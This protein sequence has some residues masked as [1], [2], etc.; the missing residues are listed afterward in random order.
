MYLGA[1]LETMSACASE[2]GLGTQVDPLS[3]QWETLLHSHIPGPLKE[4]D[5]DATTWE[6]L[7]PEFLFNF[8]RDFVVEWYE[9]YDPDCTEEDSMIR[10]KLLN[11]MCYGTMLLL[12]RDLVYVM[13]Y[14]FSGILLTN[15]FGSFLHIIV[16]FWNV[17]R[18][19][20]S[21]ASGPEELKQATGIDIPTDR[22][23]RPIYPLEA[24][25]YGKSIVCS[26]D[27]FYRANHS[28]MWWGFEE[29]KWAASK[30]GIKF[31]TG[32]QKSLT[33]FQKDISEVTFLRRKFRLLDGLW[34]APRPLEEIVEQSLWI[35]IKRQ[36]AQ[37]YLEIFEGV[38]REMIMHGRQNFDLTKKI[39]NDFLMKR[40]WPMTSMDFDQEKSR[41]YGITFAYRRT[42]TD[43]TV[44]SIVAPN[45]ILPKAHLTNVLQKPKEIDIPTIDFK[46]WQD[47]SAVFPLEFIRLPH[48]G[49]RRINIPVK[50]KDSGPVFSGM[51][52]GEGINGRRYRSANADYY[53]WWKGPDSS[54]KKVFFIERNQPKAL[55]MQYVRGVL[56]IS[57]QMMQAPSVSWKNQLQEFCQRHVLSFPVYASSRQG[58]DHMPQFAAT[59]K[60]GSE[61]QTSAH[62]FLKKV[63]AEQEAARMML[64]HL[65]PKYRGPSA[66]ARVHD[67]R[68]MLEEPQFHLKE[69]VVPP[70]MR[71]ITEEERDALCAEIAENVSAVLPM[72]EAKQMVALSLTPYTILKP[73]TPNLSRFMKAVKFVEEKMGGM[74]VAQMAE[75]TKVTDQM[76]TEVTNL[77]RMTDEAGVAPPETHPRLSSSYNINP[78]P[79][80]PIA[81]ELTRK[82]RLADITWDT[83]MSED[84]Q[85]AVYHFPKDV[86]AQPFIQDKLNNFHGMRCNIRLEFRTNGTPWHSGMYVVGWLPF[87]KHSTGAT[88]GKWKMNNLMTISD[89]NAVYGSA[90]SNKPISVLIPYVSPYMYWTDAMDQDAGYHS[91]V[92]LRVQNML[93]VREASST[94]AINISVWFN[95]EDVE[96]IAPTLHTSSVGF[97][98][99]QMQKEQKQKS[100]QGIIS[101]GLQAFKGV[102]D[103]ATRMPIVS[104]VA[105]IA[106]IGLG[107]AARVTRWFGLDKPINIQT[108]QPVFHT[109]ASSTAN[110]KGMLTSLSLNNQTDS[111]TGTEP[112]VWRLD[113]HETDL[114][115]LVARPMLIDIF[116]I[117]S[118]DTPGK[119]I[120]TWKNHPG[121]CYRIEDTDNQVIYRYLTPL[122][123]VAYNYCYWTGG[124]KYSLHFACDAYTSMRIRVAWHPTEDEI[125]SDFTTGDGDFISQVF[126]I[127]GDT[128]CEFTVPYLAET[129][130]KF[131][132]NQDGGAEP[133]MYAG[134]ISV[135]IVNSAPVISSTF[136]FSCNVFIA[137]DPDS[138]E[139]TGP[140]EKDGG[141]GGD[142]SQHTFAVNQYGLEVPL[143][144]HAQAEV[145]YNPVLAE[146][147]KRKFPS[148]IPAQQVQFHR[149]CTSEKQDTVLD[150]VHKFMPYTDQTLTSGR[151]NWVALAP[152]DPEL[153]NWE[154]AHPDPF[155]LFRIWSLFF[156]GGFNYL[157]VR[158]DNATKA[159]DGNLYAISSIN[160]ISDELN[161]TT[162]QSLSFERQVRAG[163]VVENFHF[164]PALQF[165]LD[166]LHQFPFIAN[167]F[168][169]AD[170]GVDHSL[171]TSQLVKI[172]WE[173]TGTNVGLP[174]R[175]YYSLMD[176]ASFGWFRGPPILR[177]TIPEGSVTSPPGRKGFTASVKD[178]VG[179]YKPA[180]GG[181]QPGPLKVDKNDTFQGKQPIRKL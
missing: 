146:R 34:L 110:G 174:V 111:A 106:S 91:A 19:T 170:E 75:P 61:T 25:L 94:K 60:V 46:T 171:I 73:R 50:W 136:T 52:I 83:T 79:N 108:Q 107:A 16:D 5:V 101:S 164:K 33:Y 28:F 173:E 117:S 87:Y 129:A 48:V 76:P 130:Y 166:W 104:E 126:D 30:I 169:M 80:S 74:R 92:V 147:F 54:E 102:A 149:F 178:L 121:L 43:A 115:E 27:G 42:F 62:R 119:V 154:G 118:S 165:S 89:C 153:L 18:I 20:S 181:Y 113:Q 55:D 64:E 3:R 93:Q 84:T 41:M 23:L 140:Q 4:L 95:L 40:G 71:H 51:R 122:A 177:M 128:V 96:L 68:A 143:S 156:R 32:D 88:A 11:D 81:G 162:E 145:G 168:A 85:L 97:R 175:V 100:E 9:K 157:V 131:S 17:F 132:S 44:L 77:T 137:G 144:R 56:G 59:V 49:T 161:Q 98:V 12:G 120:R 24:S 167:S 15:K 139:F 13:C 86:I 176:D 70:T 90:S 47:A 45:A 135:S 127:N 7:L 38:L 82:Y 29:W 116:E 1:F 69:E 66:Q 58:P 142:Q 123:A 124:I 179:D 163:W 53:G 57:A 2:L 152:I 160:S 21:A 158:K 63:D 31:K 138:I 148:L 125:P 8:F 141:T 37:G 26:D 35:K 155:N 134:A 114:S 180:P 22:E 67:E 159:P 133:G 6:A 72:E 109:L 105:G 112:A 39:M 151:S 99:A 172:W 14:L 78:Y 10:R 150:L 103:W 65:E 36:N